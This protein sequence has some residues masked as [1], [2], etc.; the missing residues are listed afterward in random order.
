MTKHVYHTGQLPPVPSI[1]AH[2]H[3]GRHDDGGEDDAG[4][5]RPRQKMAAGSK[6][7]GADFKAA[8]KAKRE[9]RK[10][11]PGEFVEMVGFLIDPL[12]LAHAPGRA[13][14]FLW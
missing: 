2:L 7:G 10:A 6:T 9:G 13:G 8:R 12:V 1:P 14:P 5:I 4:L 11:E 3:S